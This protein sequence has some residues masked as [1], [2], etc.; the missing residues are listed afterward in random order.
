MTS[1]HRTFVV[2][3]MASAVVDMTADGVERFPVAQLARDSLEGN[4]GSLV[5]CFVIAGDAA[6]ASDSVG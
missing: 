4:K 2:G 3:R 1:W 6:A 5:M